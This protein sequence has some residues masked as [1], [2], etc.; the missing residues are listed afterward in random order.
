MQESTEKSA[1]S[2]RGKSLKE[3]ST[4]PYV[5]S[6]LNLGIATGHWGCGAFGGNKELK[7]ILQL[8]AASEVSFS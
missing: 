2:L 5:L 8:L 3:N 4:K 6:V 1:I 7:A